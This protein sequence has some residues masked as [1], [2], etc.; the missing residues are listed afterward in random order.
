MKG[1]DSFYFG[2]VNSSQT[3]VQHNHLKSLKKW[4]TG[5]GCI[6]QIIRQIWLVAYKMWEY[7]NYVLHSTSGSLHKDERA[8]ID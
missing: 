5:K 4:T 2:I 8:A 6:S 7:R 3:E 1:W